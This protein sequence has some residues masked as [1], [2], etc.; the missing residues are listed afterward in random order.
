MPKNLRRTLI[1][2]AAV[3]LPAAVVGSLPPPIIN[4]DLTPK[5]IQFWI[6]ICKEQGLIKGNPKAE[7]LW[8]Q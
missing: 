5:Q 2:G 7:D 3:L 4:V 1:G 6:D 8:F